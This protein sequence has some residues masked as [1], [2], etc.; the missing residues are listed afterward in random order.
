M[1]KYEQFT[2]EDRVDVLLNNED[3][4]YLNGELTEENIGKAV[5]WIIACNISKKPKRT[6]KLYVN[7]TCLLYT[8]PSPRDATLSR[9]PSSA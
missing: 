3:I 8:S 6:L 9:M 7:T 1:K 2:A 5:K 4:H